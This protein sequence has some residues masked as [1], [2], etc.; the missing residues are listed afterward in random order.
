M[1]GDAQ[2]ARDMGV[3]ARAVTRA[4]GAEKLDKLSL[5]IQRLLTKPYMGHQPTKEQLIRR[6][7]IDANKLM[8]KAGTK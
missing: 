6:R 1:R 5:S 3:K 4:G 2:Y 7:A 8:R